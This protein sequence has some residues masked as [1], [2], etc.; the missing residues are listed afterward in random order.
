MSVL[1]LFTKYDN[2]LDI[3]ILMAAILDFPLFG[4]TTG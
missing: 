4:D 3:S 1:L 2:L